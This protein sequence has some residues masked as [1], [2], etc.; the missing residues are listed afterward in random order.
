MRSPARNSSRPKKAPVAGPEP[1]RPEVTDLELARAIGEV[2]EVEARLRVA[3]ENDRILVTGLKRT[4]ELK[5]ERVEKLRAAIEEQVKN[6]DLS[7]DG[8]RE[9]A[10]EG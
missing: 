8:E 7:G 4:L 6:A 9:I 3:P 2:R 5:R 1:E 10:V